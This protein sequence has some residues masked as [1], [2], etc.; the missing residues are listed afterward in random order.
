MT[1]QAAVTNLI[2][3]GVSFL[4]VGEIPTSL[5]DSIKEFANNSN[6]PLV[7]H[8]LSNCESPPISPVVFPEKSIVIF[9]DLHKAA[10]LTAH[11]V[12]LLIIEGHIVV[13]YIDSPDS[14]KF[15]PK[16]ILSMLF[17]L[18]NSFTKE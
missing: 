5:I 1:N 18:N 13:A 16:H 9:K 14:L 2:E 7:E 8:C 4:S 17:I 6:M 15:I 10:P 12:G 11:L 3:K